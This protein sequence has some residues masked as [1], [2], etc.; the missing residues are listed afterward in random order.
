MTDARATIPV[1]VLA[2]GASTRFGG[3]DKLLAQA[4]RRPVLQLTLE[5]VARAGV[6]AP[7]VVVAPGHDARHRL[8]IAFD[9][10]V[11]VATDALRGM[12]WSIAAALA[13]MAADADGVVI[14]LGDDPLAAGALGAVLEQA[15]REPGRVACIDRGERAPHPVYLPRAAWPAPPVDDLDTGLRELVGSDAAAVPAGDDAPSLDVDTHDDLRRL[16]AIV[17]EPTRSP[18]P[19]PGG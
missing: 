3:D 13:Q 9:A 6:V 2:A 8:A 7:V 15:R 4:G 14:V 17:D 1:V 12:R 19:R 10:R 11:V 18:P 5:A 16:T